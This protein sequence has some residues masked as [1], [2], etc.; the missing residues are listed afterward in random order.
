MG[1]G[2]S[3]VNFEDVRKMQ[4]KYEEKERIEAWKKRREEKSKKIAEMHDKATSYAKALYRFEEQE[5]IKEKG[6]KLN[7]KEREQLYMRY[8]A[9]VQAFVAMEKKNERERIKADRFKEAF[10]DD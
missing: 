1:K 8:E 3:S 9:N 2:Y 6:R 7:K 4:R 10:G 5:M